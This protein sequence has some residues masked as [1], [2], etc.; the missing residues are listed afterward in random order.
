M[1]TVEIVTTPAEDRQ[2]A[3]SFHYEPHLARHIDW[4]KIA[5]IAAE[6]GADFEA[7][8]GRDRSCTISIFWAAG[9][10]VHPRF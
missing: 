1:A 9:S 8:W 6:C 2:I 4:N 7:R 5:E 10:G 3:S